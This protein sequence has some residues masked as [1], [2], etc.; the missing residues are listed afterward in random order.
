MF[1]CFIF[2]LFDL[3]SAPPLSLNQIGYAMGMLCLVC[4]IGS[5]Y[6]GFRVWNGDVT[7]ANA[8][9]C[10]FV[11]FSGLAGLPEPG[12]CAATG[13]DPDCRKAIALGFCI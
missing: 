9:H 10:L 1:S 5:L 6:L 8:E 2:G 13:N 11:S 3:I 7:L 4:I 12:M